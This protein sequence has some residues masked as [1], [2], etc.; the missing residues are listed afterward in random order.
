V[1]VFLTRQ[2]AFNLARRLHNP[3]LSDE[4][5]RRIYGDANNPHG[6]GHNLILEVTVGG[7]IDSGD[8]MVMNLVDLER[9]LRAEIHDPLDHRNVNYEVEPF[10][11]IP[12]TAENLIA[13]MWE[14]IA[15]ALPARARLAHLRLEVTSDFRVDLGN[16]QIAGTF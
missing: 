15:K 16:P 3:A 1:P 8:G 10:D 14:R 7:E 2:I 13:W 5:N 4:E 11:R 12:P 9:I 6:F